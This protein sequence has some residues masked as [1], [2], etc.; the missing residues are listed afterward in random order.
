MNEKE[1]NYLLTNFAC[2]RLDT[3]AEWLREK[4]CDRRFI[5]DVIDASLKQSIKNVTDRS[6][7][8]KKLLM[9]LKN[10]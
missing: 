10:K 7:K 2:D 8:Y 9:E 4:D 5:H 3:L 1:L 6:N